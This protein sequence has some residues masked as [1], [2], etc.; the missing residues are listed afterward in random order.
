MDDDNP[1]LVL[2]GVSGSILQLIVQALYTGQVTLDG[3]TQLRQFET[4]LTCLN[5][6]GIL[7]NLRP[8]VQVVITETEKEDTDSEIEE[9]EAKSKK[10][11]ISI[12]NENDSDEETEEEPKDDEIEPA[13]KRTRAS[14]AIGKNEA[15]KPNF[16]NVTPELLNN[17]MKEGHLPFVRWLQQEGFLKD[18]PP[19]CTIKDCLKQPMEL[20]EDQESIDGVSWKCAHCPNKT[21]IREG[22]IFGRHKKSVDSLSWII[23][24]ILCWSDN[25]SLMQCQQMTGADVDKIF[26]WYDECKD[27]YGAL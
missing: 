23:Q 22:S 5:S 2:S 21:N 1:C 3:K 18:S 7:L 6:F 10:R 12:E 19:T 24:I 25:T 14:A 13:R 11:K 20:L 27:Y 9:V 15:T 17:K 8:G 26:L 16:D 4:A